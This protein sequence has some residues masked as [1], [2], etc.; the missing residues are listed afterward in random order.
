MTNVYFHLE[1]DVL[2]DDGF[3]YLAEGLDELGIACFGNRD[4]WS[5]RT[6]DG[7][8]IRQTALEAHPWDVAFVSNTAYR[9]DVIDAQGRYHI[10]ERA[11]DW[12][13][14]ARHAR[15]VV[16]IDLQD[17]YSDYGAA[18]PLIRVIYRAKF[19]R[20]CRQSTKSRPYV[21]GMGQRC[22]SLAPR[23]SD[24]TEN[25]RAV[26]DSFGFTHNYA[27]GTRH[28]FRTEISPLLARHGV[29]T[30]REMA[31][32]LHAAPTE[33]VAAHWWRLTHGKHNPGYYDLIRRY[34]M[35]AC[36]CG[37]LIPAFPADPTSIIQ[38]GGRA[39]V[40]RAAYTALAQLLF[41]PER[42][43]QWDSWRFWETLALGSVPL[44]FDLEA[45]GVRLPVMPQNW[46]HYVGLD[47]RRPEASVEALVRRWSELPR[48]AAQGRAWLFEHYSPAANAR[49]LC[50][51]LGL[52]ARL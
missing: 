37:D 31:G 7:P 3:A 14:L 29:V 1:P 23:P 51:E 41:R 39:R 4:H 36:F 26:L 48:I 52:P 15:Q 6:M 45:V 13:E 49:R 9:Y 27:H 50:H 11:P 38:G 33:P 5:R 2:Y 28:R 17:G 30:Q 18:D 10:R 8:I 35:H 19:N 20:H 34:P 24:S 32:S 46:V 47:P 22:L 12:S 25:A 21:L 43:L 40:R 44:M 16:L 42:L